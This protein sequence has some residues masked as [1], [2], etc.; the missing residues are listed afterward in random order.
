MTRIV[1][2]RDTL[3]TLCNLRRISYRSTIGRGRSHASSR[4][5]HSRGCAPRNHG[6]ALHDR[7]ASRRPAPTAS[8]DSGLPASSAWRTHHARERGPAELAGS[9]AGSLNRHSSVRFKRPV[10]FSRKAISLRS[11][12]FSSA[13]LSISW[14]ETGG[15]FADARATYCGV[16][17]RMK[18]AGS[19]GP[20]P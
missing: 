18:G 10:P 15:V 2:G 20:E 7:A 3:Q 16:S 14:N 19:A 5:D 17:V 13:Y 6:A 1:P 8:R 12:A 11:S 4:W 9:L